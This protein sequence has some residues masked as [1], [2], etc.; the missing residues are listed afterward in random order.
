MLFAPD[1]IL[2]ALVPGLPRSGVWLG[3]LLG[4]AWL[5]IA[6]LNWLQRRA[7][8]GGIYGRPTVLANAILYF[9]GSMSLLKVLLS[10]DSPPPIE[11]WLIAIPSALLAVAYALLLFRGP[12]DQIK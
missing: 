2:A 10:G 7:V 1:I 11:L 3:Q 12:F 8:L 5:G 4:A 9:V 6:A